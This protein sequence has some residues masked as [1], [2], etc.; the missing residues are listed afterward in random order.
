MPI[1]SKPFEVPKLT[2]RER[3]YMT[4]RDWITDGTLKPDEKISDL[5]I[6]K[7]F[8][9][10]R[11]PVREAMQLLSDQKLIEIFPGKESRV[12]TIDSKNIVQVYMMLS[13]LHGMAVQFSYPKID[14]EIIQE[15]EGINEEFR[16]ASQ[17]FNLENIRINDKKF[18]DVFVKL[19][20]NDF[21]TNFTELLY[22][23]VLRIEN[24]YYTRQKDYMISADEHIK[25]VDALKVNDLD[26]A[27]IS[28][29][30]NWTHTADVI[31]VL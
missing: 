10:S 8:S 12:T 1:P 20:E 16:C 17:E 6:S 19:A 24:L 14:N 28:M 27:V 13:E 23:H 9:V 2:A 25:I 31:S 4:L 21:L 22:I 18:H 30:Y 7:Y 26:A 3:V 29:K 5:E 15:L 11:T